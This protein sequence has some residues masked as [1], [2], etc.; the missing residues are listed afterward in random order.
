MKEKAEKINVNGTPS[1]F[2]A[3]LFP[4]NITIYTTTTTTT[5][6]HKELIISMLPYNLSVICKHSEEE[7]VRYQMLLRRKKPREN[8]ILPT[9]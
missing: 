3:L 8:Q 2:S 7:P 4:K 6:R 5:S 9:I 1:S